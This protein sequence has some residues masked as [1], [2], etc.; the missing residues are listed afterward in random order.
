MKFI[1]YRGDVYV[2]VEHHSYQLF[3]GNEQVKLDSLMFDMAENI[4]DQG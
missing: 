4:I 1:K 3:S 2:V